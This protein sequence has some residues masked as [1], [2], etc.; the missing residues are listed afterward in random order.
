MIS[1]K[2]AKNILK[3]SKIILQNEIIKTS[4]CLNR[5]VAQDVLSKYNNPAGNNAA[6]D[7]YAIDSKDTNNLK[8][9]KGRLF[10]IIGIVAAGDKPNKKKKQKFQTIE[11]MTGGLLPKGFDNIGEIWASA[12][13][14]LATGGGCIALSTP[15]GTGNWFHQTWVRAEN[16]ENQFLS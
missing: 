9:D 8:K 15:Y 6:F 1:Y 10:R 11:I 4:D 14:T 5:V 3:S 13:Q 12:Q 7:G 2:R 16:R